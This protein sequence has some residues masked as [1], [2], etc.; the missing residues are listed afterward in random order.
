M[1]TRTLTI[2]RELLTSLDVHN[3]ED[4]TVIYESVLAC[5][6][7][8]DNYAT[9]SSV[10]M[11]L[12]EKG[13]LTATQLKR[14]LDFSKEVYASYLAVALYSDQSLAM[15]EE[16][17]MLE[18]FFRSPELS[19]QLKSLGLYSYGLALSISNPK[20]S[21]DLTVEAFDI[22][23]EL[24]QLL[25]INYS[26]SEYKK[27]EVIT[28]ECPICKS[29]EVTPY[30]C[31]QQLL[32]L[33]NNNNFPPA[34]LWMRCGKCEN[35]YTYDFPIMKVGDINGH[36]TRNNKAA[37]LENRFPLEVYNS[38][39][40]QLSSLTDG[41][42]Y[43][44]IGVGNGEM[45]AV[46]QEF[47][48]NVDAVE[49]CKEDC[50]KISAALNVDIKWC[51]VANYMT[52]KKYDVIIMGDV[53][54]H[55]T[56]PVEVLK[57]VCDMLTDDGVL[58]LSTPN[59]NCAYARMQRFKHCMWHELNHYTYVSKETIEKLLESMGMKIISYD[60]SKRYIGSMEL[61]IK[62]NRNN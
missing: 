60:I 54:E 56:A 47:G 14:W 62:R 25:N 29:G 15:V 49:I 57:K 52:D 23:P 61:C 27:N 9:Q 50:E 32:K 36:Y 6:N 13:F 31:S 24:G 16:P 4:V 44:E 19:A 51:D 58:W 8:K 2:F 21:Y 37:E 40:N 33:N 55:V 45:L 17:E 18:E 12:L 42:E 38:I 22:Y 1:I 30:Y 39:F 59:Y 7:D 5:C 28:E 35:Y 43:L 48:Y 10:T 3:K 20:K 26:Y 34:K 46:A 11:E 41:K 53:F